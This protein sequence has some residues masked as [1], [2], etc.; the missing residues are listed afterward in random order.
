MP[1][2]GDV[3]R[4]ILPVSVER[5]DPR[6]MRRLNARA[7]RRALTVISRVPQQP[8]LWGSS[9]GSQDLGGGR[10]AATVVYEDDLIIGQ[11]IERGAN[12]ADECSDIFSL[13]LYRDDD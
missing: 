6:R 3:S 9:R 13:V 10:I 4:V 12:L 1:H 8:H 5:R 7:N 2:C 11:T